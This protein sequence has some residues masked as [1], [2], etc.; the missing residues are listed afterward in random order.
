[1]KTST[2]SKYIFIYGSQVGKTTHCIHLLEQMKGRVIM[3]NHSEKYEQLFVLDAFANRRAWLEKAK[4]AYNA[5]GKSTDFKNYKG[6]PM[7]E[8]DSLPEAIQIAWGSA[9]KA[10][11]EEDRTIHGKRAFSPSSSFA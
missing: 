8:W 4:L 1:M 11:I 5:Y 10:V 7:P 3:A 6:L 9:V 2:N